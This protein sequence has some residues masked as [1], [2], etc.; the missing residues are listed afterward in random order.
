MAVRPSPT[1]RLSGLASLGLSAD[2]CAMANH[3]IT[4]SGMGLVVTDMAASVAFY[5]RLGLAIADSDVYAEDGL[6]HHLEIKMDAGAGLEVDTLE[7][8]RRFDPNFPEPVAT[9]T[10]VAMF[11]L[12][13]RDAVDAKHDELVTAG[14]KSHLAPFDAFWGARYAVVLDP[15]GNQVGLMSPQEEH[16]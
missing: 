12:P 7:L 2:T 16:A 10:T 14:A 11:S 15:D 5:R 1:A 4:F 13:S 3:A 9:S 8:T 6:G